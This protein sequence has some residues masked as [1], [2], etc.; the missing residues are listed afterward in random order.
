[1]NRVLTASLTGAFLFM[2]GPI[3]ARG[4]HLPEGEGKSASPKPLHCLS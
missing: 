4:Q 1:M 3:T 2:I